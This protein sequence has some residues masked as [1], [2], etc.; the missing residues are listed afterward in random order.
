MLVTI[1]CIAKLYEREAFAEAAGRSFLLE[2]LP[3]LQQ[4]LLCIDG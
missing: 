1:H 3:N 2:A 4:Y